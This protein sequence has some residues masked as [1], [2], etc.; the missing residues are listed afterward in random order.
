V[1]LFGGLAHAV[2]ALRRA[3]PGIDVVWQGAPAPPAGVQVGPVLVRPPLGR[4]STSWIREDLT[5]LLGTRTNADAEARLRRALAAADPALL[6]RLRFD[7]EA[8]A[9]HVDAEREEDLHAVA[10]VIERSAAKEP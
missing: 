1:E 2:E 6:T 3:R 9:V 5:E 8:E 4:R 7:T 10:R